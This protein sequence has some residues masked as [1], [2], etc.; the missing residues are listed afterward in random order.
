M[1]HLLYYTK[2]AAVWEEALPLGN[3][4]MGAMIYGGFD[5]EMIRLNHMELWSG[6][7]Y[8]KIPDNKT[9]KINTIRD[10]ISQKKYSEATKMADTLCENNSANYLPMG[11]I[12]LTRYCDNNP[13]IYKRSLDLKTAT[14]EVY[15]R[16]V[17]P[18]DSVR[19][20]FISHPHNIMIV[21]ITN[22]S[23]YPDKNG[24]RVSKVPQRWVVL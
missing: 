3:G 21:D 18:V 24:I 10:L 19:K 9:E 14:S 16:E 8:Q 20:A 13:K 17:F 11:D 1:E 23:P 7:A 15:I 22:N 2:P 6:E 4:I 12:L 5:N